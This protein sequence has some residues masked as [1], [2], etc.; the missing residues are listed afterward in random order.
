MRSTWRTAE[1]AEFAPIF[2]EVFGEPL[3]AAMA[4]LEVVGSCLDPGGHGPEHQLSRRTSSSPAATDRDHPA[5]ACAL[6]PL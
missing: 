2:A 1:F 6:R 3:E 4:G 5:L